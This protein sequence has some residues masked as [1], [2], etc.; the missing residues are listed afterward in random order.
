VF[1]ERHICINH[2]EFGGQKQKQE[3]RGGTTEVLGAGGPWPDSVS[4]HCN[5]NFNNC[6]RFMNIPKHNI[7]LECL[8]SSS[9]F[10]PLLALI[11]LFL[12]LLTSV[13][14]LRPCSP[15][16]LA[17]PATRR[18]ALPPTAFPPVSP[19][20]LPVPDAAPQSACAPYP[21]LRPAAASNRSH[22][23]ASNRIHAAASSPPSQQQYCACPLARS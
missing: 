14:P 1:A 6:V 12:L 10:H 8:G 21:L 5:S 16:P 9:D 13:L 20:A 11:P 18:A 23:A 15:L 17:A 3:G 2:L 22:A 4:L 7:C 19:H